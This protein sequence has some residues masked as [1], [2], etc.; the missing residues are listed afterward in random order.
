M[1]RGFAGAVVGG[2]DAHDEAV[3][4]GGCRATASPG[5]TIA[6]EFYSYEGLS[7]YSTSAENETTQQ[8]FQDSLDCL[9]GFLEG[10]K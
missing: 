7:H 2:T 5:D 9:Q 4:A 8:M 3:G 10:E 1:G 6:L